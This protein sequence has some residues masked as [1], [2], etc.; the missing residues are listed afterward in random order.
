VTSVSRS[1]AG[2]P[3][4][5]PVEPGL[6]E[7]LSRI[8]S[9]DRVLSRPLDRLGRSADASIYRLIPEVVVRPRDLA[10]VRELLA[11]CR[12]HGRHVTFRT[13]GTSL[14]GQAVGDG[15]LVEL[16][17]FWKAWRILDGGRRVSAQ[18]GVVGGTLNKM[19][20]P[21]GV[22]IGPDPASIDAA[23]M[24]GIVSNNS[25]GMC[26]GVVEN[27]YHT[28][29]ALAFLLADGT[30]V[31]TARPDADRTLRRERP[32]LHAAVLKLR[33]DVR[34]DGELSE[35]IRRKFARKNTTG[36]SLNAFL[37]FDRPADILAHLMVGAQGTLGFLAEIVL[38][39]V[40]EPPA[41]ATALLYFEDIREAGA[42]V[43]PLA[44][45]GAAA[46]EIMDSA[47]LRSLA[48][49]QAHP[50]AIT[51]QSAALLTEFRTGD[52]ASLAAAV[53]D[54][55]RALAPFRLLLPAR[56]TTDPDERAH[57]WHLRKGLAATTGALRPS[58]TAFLTE[59]V[60]VPVERLA[61]AI[62]DFQDL[63]ARY[64]VPDTIQFGHAKD[65]NLHFVLAEDLR[66]DRAVERY[67]RFLQGMV[68][69]V[70]GKYDGAIKAEHGSGRNMAPFVRT[71]WG[72]DAYAL[73]R[74]IKQLLD[75]DGILNPG[76]VLNDDPRV[77]L[78]D[79]K[80]MPAI[81]LL[82]DRCIECG[83]CE[84][85]CPSR[86]LSLS[87][88]Q[89]IVVV[90][91][92]A[93][94]GATAGAEAAALKAALE[95]D[96][97]YEGILTCAGD[98]MCQTS[99]PVKIDTGALVK[100]LKASLH[101]GWSRGLAAAA[102]ESFGATAAVLRLG[103]AAAA[104][105]R[106]LPFGGRVLDLLTGALHE[107]MP[108]LVPRLRPEI[109]LP[110]PA[111]ALPKDVEP[112]AAV[113]GGSA[114][115]VVYFPSCLT[116]ILG[117][118][119]GE[120][121]P[122]LARSALQVF[123]W[124]GYRVSLPEAVDG[125]CCGMPFASKGF[126]DAARR[127]AARTAEALWTAARYGRDPVVTDASPC[128]GTLLD[129]ACKILGEDGRALRVLDFAAFWAREVL[130]GRGSLPR[131][132]GTAV[133]HPTCTLVK[134]GGLPDLLAVARAHAESVLVP[135]S[136]ECCGFAGDRGFLVPELT[137]SATAREAAEVRTMAPPAAGYY[138]TCRT[139]EIGMSRAVGRSY[140]SLVHLVHEAV[141]R[142]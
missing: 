51:K 66:S 136:A 81:S 119:P 65:G 106:A 62:A 35:R 93:R 60:A 40:P 98:S 61:E 57:L 28:L 118:L 39:T 142:A 111:P 120:D 139:C 126:P 26:C 25:S 19:L 4:L 134:T 55:T 69:L 8:L 99:C 7:G 17:P 59:D 88:R 68:D 128:A 24:G 121:G 92:I 113:A 117:P 72:D 56:F 50:F 114:R 73:M 75:P 135:L 84:P 91:E 43:H 20:A 87:P 133:L 83:L 109:A 31:D 41:R 101:P 63:F 90:R 29:E 110:E 49:E 3:P 37:D 5:R 22:R 52:P 78:K 127:A 125:L 77:H 112:A 14:S 129:L 105:L 71:E 115:R 13:A 131:R 102:A 36:Y 34:A 130:P 27:S 140:R 23:M 70:V 38:R 30:Y 10:E 107:M 85:R 48:G 33:D 11:Y 74:R 21:L 123:R 76:V 15:I 16:G 32:D 2:L 6:V 80:P 58:G 103:L 18:P 122:A 42:A 141:V 67:G 116:R 95:A 97:E 47:C 1:G 86:D 124:A 89:R 46:L 9:R 104:G 12:G 96:Y 138:S 137:A 94:L 79:L 82:A 108:S 100:E 54:G 132:H 53:A 45:A 64:D 44:T